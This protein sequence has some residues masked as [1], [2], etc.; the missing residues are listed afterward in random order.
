MYTKSQLND[1]ALLNSFQTTGDRKAFEQLFHRYYAPL[2]RLSLSIAKSSD[3]AEEVV[4]D[5]FLKIWQK[6]LE[7]NI[8]SSV[9]AYLVMSV[10]NR[11]IDYLR[12]IARERDKSCELVG[13]YES[14]Y[15]SPYQLV[16][17]DELNTLIESSINALSPQCRTIFRLN[18]DAGLTYNE[19]ATEMGL[20]IK[21]IE[22]HMGRALRFLRERILTD[23][24][25][26]AA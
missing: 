20:S 18:R 13:D 15:A 24:Y 4:S 8:T 17:A 6:R 2:C 19:I 1:Y 9:H 25:R 7:L 14:N 26:A 22:T 5:V 3:V 12:K 21:T 11:T 23:Q 10:R 16:V